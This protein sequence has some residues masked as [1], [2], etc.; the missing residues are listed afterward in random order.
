[1]N[2]HGLKQQSLI[3]R[4]SIGIIIYLNMEKMVVRQLIGGVFSVAQYGKKVTEDEY[5]FHAFSKKATMLKLGKT[6]YYGKKFIK[7]INWWLDKGI[8]G[9]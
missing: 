3:R 5:Y 8:A 4:V 1:M 2:T 7:M 6:L 9:F